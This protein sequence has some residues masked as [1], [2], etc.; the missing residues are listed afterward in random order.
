MHGAKA[1]ELYIS[2][3]CTCPSLLSFHLK[4]HQLLC[5]MLKVSSEKDFAVNNE[6]LSRCPFLF[7]KC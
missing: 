6:P 3:I 5:E 1:V 2:I 7:E 4:F